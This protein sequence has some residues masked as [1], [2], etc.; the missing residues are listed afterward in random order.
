[1]R[2]RV[3]AF[4][5]PAP[6]EPASAGPDSGASLEAMFALAARCVRLVPELQERVERLEAEL[7][8][9]K[10][11]KGLSR[12]GTAAEVAH[13]FRIART[14]VYELLD[15]PKFSAAIVRRGKRGQRAKVLIDRH[16]F[17]RIFTEG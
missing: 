12:L 3:A 1:M 13:E 6:A 14:Y 4:P 7:A 16:I 9:L 2:S 17:R 5:A 11:G 8:G 10:A 15:Q